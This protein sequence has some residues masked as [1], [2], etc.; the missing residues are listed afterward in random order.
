M[1][2]TTIVLGD[3]ILSY[4]GHMKGLYVS[5]SLKLVM[6]M[7]LILTRSLGATRKMPLLGQHI[8]LL[9]QDPPSLFFPHSR[10]ANNQM[11]PG[12]SVATE[13]TP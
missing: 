1:N 5:I 12:S 13:S 2:N 11:E 10:E 6:I 3:P 9:V 7:S 8:K 4:S